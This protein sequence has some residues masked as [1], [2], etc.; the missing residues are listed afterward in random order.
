MFIRVLPTALAALLLSVSVQVQA[1]HAMHG[2]SEMGEAAVQ[3]MP[4]NNAVLASSPDH[5]MLQFEDEI[6][7]VKLA[8]KNP[9]GKLVDIG[10]R[11]DPKPAMHYMQM[12]P[13][14]EQI[15]FYSVEWAILKGDGELVK[16]TFYFSFGPDARPPSY[17]LE[18]MDMPAHM[19]S[20]DYRLL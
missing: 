16:G 9:A 3:T 15:D 20:P 8:V 13:E 4:A 7:L 19:M 18:Q 17:Y 1:Q 14:L 10:F 6:T 12:L 5:L 2:M 11:F